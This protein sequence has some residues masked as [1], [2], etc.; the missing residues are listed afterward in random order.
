MSLPERA[1]VQN[2]AAGAGGVLEEA[3]AL[4]VQHQ[5]LVVIIDLLCGP[6][7]RE[8]RFEQGMRRADIHLRSDQAE[9]SGD[10][11]VVAVH[12]QGTAV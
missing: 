4:T 8:L 3:A 10:T 5:D 6:V 9:T 11:V 2:D 12:G 1:Q 7:G